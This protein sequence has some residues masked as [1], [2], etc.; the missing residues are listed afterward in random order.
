MKTYFISFLLI[1]SLWS[2]AQSNLDS[3]WTVWE[4]QL[5][6]DTIKFNAIKHLVKSYY[7]KG[8]LDSSI[9]VAKLGIERA[10][11]I[12]STT[13]NQQNE[14]RIKEYKNEVLMCT[15]EGDIDQT[16]KYKKHWIVTN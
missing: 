4:D 5:Q 9:V 3:L 12:L 6:E 13:N 7:E 14:N 16:T 2:N 15:F 8:N 11:E 1:F 10:T